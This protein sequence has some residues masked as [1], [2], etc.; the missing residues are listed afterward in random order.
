MSKAVN[1]HRLKENGLLELSEKCTFE[2]YVPKEQWQYAFKEK[3]LEYACEWKNNSF[4]VSGQSGSGKTHIVTAIYNKAFESGASLCYFQWVRDSTKLKGLVND[5]ESYKAAIKECMN[6]D[7]LCIDDFFKQ[8]VTD[9]DIRLAYEIINGRY[10]SEK[11][12]IISSERDLTFIRNIRSSD[13]EAI[14]GRIYEMCGKGKYCIQLSGV[15]KNQR[16]KG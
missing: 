13:G 5:P 14:A 10:I 9:A 8:S 2:S 6:A 4:F 1:R 16:F 15:D 12:V 11:P 3:A 7:L